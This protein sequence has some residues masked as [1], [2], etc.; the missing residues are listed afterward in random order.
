[1]TRTLLLLPLLLASLWG[2]P[3]D[4]PPP[5]ELAFEDG[6]IQT[7]ADYRGQWVVINYWATWCKPCLKEIPH[8]NRLHAERQGSVAVMGVD[9]DKGQGD[10]L[11]E[12][13]HTMGITFPVLKHDPAP[14]M[15]HARPNVLPTTVIY[16]PE[17]KLHATLLGDQSWESLQQ[18]LQP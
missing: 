3:A 5:V 12:R 18:A 4:Q 1:M 10:V 15:L 17:G 11:A 2:C 9:F 7:L 8:F 6:R 14:G 13:I 16:N